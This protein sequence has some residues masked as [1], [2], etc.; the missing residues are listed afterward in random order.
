MEI[1]A[2]RLSADSLQMHI[3]VIFLV[4]LIVL[5]PKEIC[6]NELSASAAGSSDAA[7]LSNHFKPK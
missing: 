6:A 7:I 2:K 4:Q 1:R 3:A 5:Y